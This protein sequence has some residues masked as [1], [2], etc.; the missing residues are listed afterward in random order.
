M[1]LL[2]SQ[3]LINRIVMILNVPLLLYRYQV[4]FAGFV[5]S[6]NYLR[7]AHS[8]MLQTCIMYLNECD[9][10]LLELHWRC[11]STSVAIIASYCSWVLTAMAFTH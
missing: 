1:K 4:M 8:L 9:Y 5:I 2:L 3:L 11:H 6:P 7:L 10:M